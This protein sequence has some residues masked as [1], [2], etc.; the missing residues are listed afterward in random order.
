MQLKEEDQVLGGLGTLE[1][2]GNLVCAAEIGRDRQIC[3]QMTAARLRLLLL[4]V[5]QGSTGRPRSKRRSR[6]GKLYPPWH[7]PDQMLSSP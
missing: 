5:L 3:Q 1:A 6:G 4:G 7:L 2:Q